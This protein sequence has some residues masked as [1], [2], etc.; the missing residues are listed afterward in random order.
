V[1]GQ[2]AQYLFVTRLF[3]R[4]KAAERSTAPEGFL[5]GELLK[6][7][8]EVTLQIVCLHL[9]MKHPTLTR[10]TST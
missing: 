9:G 5:W 1:P 2:N 8:S 3:V 7:M 4:K 6:W 10:K